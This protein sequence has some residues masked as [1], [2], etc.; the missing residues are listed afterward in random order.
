MA[1]AE[2]FPTLVSW[3][4]SNPQRSTNFVFRRIIYHA[5]ATGQHMTSRQ[6][7]FINFFSFL[8]PGPGCRQSE[9]PWQNG[10]F[11]SLPGPGSR[12]VVGRY[13]F[14]LLYSF[15]AFSKMEILSETEFKLHSMPYGLTAR[16]WRI[17]PPVL[18]RLNLHIFRLAKLA[19]DPLTWNDRVC[20]YSP[21]SGHGRCN[22]WVTRT[23]YND[24]YLVEEW[25]N[26]TNLQR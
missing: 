17:D 13:T 16:H 24:L 2:C 20:H 8:R 23:V 26:N 22:E 10:R 14:I 25:W 21:V 9:G 6:Q 5:G 19:D 4:F 12:L 7:G 1:L 18:Q 15:K 11:P 3:V